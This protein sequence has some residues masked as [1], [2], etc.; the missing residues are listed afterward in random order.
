V[1]P[2]TRKARKV[3]EISTAVAVTMRPMR[4]RPMATA[5]V[6]DPVRS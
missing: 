4:S 3:I 6:P 2:D 5:A 1:M